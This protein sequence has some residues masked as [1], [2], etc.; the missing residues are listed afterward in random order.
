MKEVKKIVQNY[1][2]SFSEGT[3]AGHGLVFYCL[4]LFALFIFIFSLP[5]T[6]C[7][8]DPFYKTFGIIAGS[9]AFGFPI[10]SY[11]LCKITSRKFISVPPEKRSCHDSALLL[12]RD[13]QVISRIG[14]AFGYQEE[15]INLQKPIWKKGIIYQ[16]VTGWKG[17]AYWHY[18]KND[19]NGNTEDVF[20][21]ETE[22]SGRHKN[23]TITI[24]V[25]IKIY[26]GEEFDPI[27]V[28]NKISP[29]P[30]ETTILLGKY[31]QD[32][33]VR[34]NEKNQEGIQ[35]LITEYAEM[36]ISDSVLMSEIVDLLIFPEKLFSNIEDVQICLDTPITTSCKGM[37]CGK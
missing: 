11:L 23:S 17:V 16:I 14:V 22:V 13:E 8:C 27:E 12:V 35:K 34:I 18:S 2:L 25:K 15:K 24:P 28:F 6:E 9:I 4:F 33:F 32:F 5:L 19:E 36:K 29:G 30:K 10:V 26:T 1:F 21:I 3:G 20:V 31:L 7:L 37:V